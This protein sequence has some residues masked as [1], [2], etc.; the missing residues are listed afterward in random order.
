MHGWF[1][2]ALRCFHQSSTTTFFYLLTKTERVAMA[3]FVLFFPR[4]R[5]VCAQ[6]HF[7]RIEV[8]Q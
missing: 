7:R 3:Y 2:N 8:A 5:N 4:R 6:L 1:L